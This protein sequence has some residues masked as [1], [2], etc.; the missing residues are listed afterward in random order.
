MSN[1]RTKQNIDQSL[2]HLFAFLL[3]S[4]EFFKSIYIKKTRLVLNEVEINVLEKFL[5]DRFTVGRQ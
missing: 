5:F 1:R 2:I 3:Q 4:D